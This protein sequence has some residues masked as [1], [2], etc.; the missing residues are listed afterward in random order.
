[1]SK[2][3]KKASDIFNSSEPF[4]G[5]K[6]SFVEAF[7]QIAKIKVEVEEYKDFWYKKEVPYPVN[8]FYNEANLGQYIN[9]SEASCYGGGFNVGSIINE[10]VRNKQVFLDGNIKCKGNIGN[11]KGQSCTHQFKYKIS[12]VYK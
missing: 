9:C 12:I 5:K 1:M 6:V 4:L 7:P 11:P 2:R 10:M 3:R 8:H